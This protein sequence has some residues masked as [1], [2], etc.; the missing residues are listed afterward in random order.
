M[1]SL[2]SKKHSIFSF[3]D[4]CFDVERDRESAARVVVWREF[5]IRNSYTC[6]ASFCGPSIG[7][8]AGYHFNPYI[9]T[10]HQITKAIGV[11][12]E[13]LRDADRDA[14]SEEGWRDSERAGDNVP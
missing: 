14:E 10:V 11:W 5:D 9:Y 2:L 13:V 6:E 4:C 1:N 8:Y 7:E 12:E 3:E